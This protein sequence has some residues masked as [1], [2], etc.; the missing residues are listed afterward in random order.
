MESLR[1]GLP[2][3]DFLRA[4]RRELRRLRVPA[5]LEWAYDLVHGRRRGRGRRDVERRLG[6]LVVAPEN[7]GQRSLFGRG[8]RDVWL[9]QGA[10]R[11]QRVRRGRVVEAWFVPSAGHEPWQRANRPP[12]RLLPDL[13]QRTAEV[14]PPSIV[15]QEPVM[16]A[17]A[18]EQRKTTSR[19]TSDGIPSRPAG[20]RPT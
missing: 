5:L 14:A 4:W 12:A 6:A 1:F 3:P 13:G 11:I 17:P 16:Y 8:F 20:T 7:A 19:P 18:S 15:M 10:G 9:A 2:D